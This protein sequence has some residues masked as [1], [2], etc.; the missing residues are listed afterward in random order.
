MK[1]LTVTAYV[2]T[3]D[4]HE[5]TLPLCIMSLLHQ[6]R[7]P[8]K[9]VIYD[10]TD[11]SEAKWN[12]TVPNW[13]E[14]W[15]WQNIFGIM[16][17]KLGGNWYWYFG[18]R[19]GQVKNHEKALRNS[20]TDL[21]WRVDDD[22]YAEPNVCER[23]MSYFENDEG[24]EIG[25]VGQNVWHP[26]RPITPVPAFAKNKMTKGL[27]HQVAEWF[28]IPDGK[29]RPAEHLYSTFMYR[30]A[31][32]IEAGGYPLDL[33][34]VGHHEETI[35]SHK[36]H[37]AGYKLLVTPSCKLWHLRNPNGGIR[38]YTQEWLWH[39]D[40]LTQD[41]YMEQWNYNDRPT[42]IL[43]SNSGIGDGYA[44]KQAISAIK[45]KFEATHELVVAANMPEIFTDCGLQVIPLPDYEMFTGRKF[46]N[47]NIYQFMTSQNDPELKL[48]QA[49]IKFYTE[50]H[51]EK[52]A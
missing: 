40:Q 41:R 19:K 5:T 9:L 36:I 29:D 44:L 31:A 12:G 7:L 30:K 50:G 6:S 2:S 45:A 3:R 37:R 11:Y 46:D 1:K 38:A 24:G 17:Q 23:L 10:D 35:F 4:R 22:N 51:D 32:G 49:Y 13:Q 33:S 39:Q 16:Q 21:I 47:F 20:D 18:E 26:N 14:H 48:Y 42:K 28:Y 25:A 43:I 15:L 34:P 8:D 52:I 27:N